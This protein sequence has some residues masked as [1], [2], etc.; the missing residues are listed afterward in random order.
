LELRVSEEMN[1]MIDEFFTEE[2]LK[3][4]LRSFIQDKKNEGTN[5]STI[6]R[7]T[8]YMLGGSSPLID[9][10]AALTELILLGLDIVDDLQDQD[11]KDKPWMA[12]PQEVSLN[13]LISYFSIFMGELGSLQ[14]GS[15]ARAGYWVREASG[16]LA[17][18]IDGQHQDITRSVQTEE[19]YI[20][21]VQQKSG[22]LIR[23]ACAM[24]CFLLDSLDGDTAEK[25]QQLSYCIGI[26]AQIDNDLNDVMRFDLKNDVLQ[27]KRTLPILFL[28]VD[29]KEEFPILDHYYEGTLSQAEFLLHKNACI[30]YIQD[31]GCIEYCRIIQSLY[32]ERAEKLL[33]AIPAVSPWKERFREIT[34]P[35]R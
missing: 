21:M 23:L 22:S 25:I 31:S 30:Q 28:L 33:D 24:G 27:K 2:D 16:L 11:N 7:Y 19:Q 18:A 29:S 20:Q 26:I 15:S 17:A 32:V 6:T 5:W 8:H 10:C 1:R 13:A 3:K 14:G 35:R 4:V 9:R 12:G 34:F